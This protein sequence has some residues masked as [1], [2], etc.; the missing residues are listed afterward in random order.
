MET[1]TKN[2][3][4]GHVAASICMLIWGITFISSKVLLTHFSPTELFYFRF[5]LAYVF[6]FILSPKPIVPKLN[7]TELL[8]A[9]SGLTGVSLYFMFQNIGLQYTL[10]SNAGV[11]VAVAPM[12][13]AIVS[14]FFVSRSSLHR[15]FILG[16]FVSIA[17]VAIISFNGN[18]VLQLNPLGDLLIILGALAWGF[19]SNILIMIEEDGLSLIQRTRKAAFYGLLFVTP[20]L[21]FLDF[22]FG[23]E[24]FDNFQIIGNFLFLGIAASAISFVAWGYAVR[25]L[26]PVKAATYIY[27]NPIITVVA[28]II[29]LHEPFTWISFMGTALIIVGLLIAERRR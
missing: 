26:G 14:F 13:T 3:I 19:Y 24:R 8:Y 21:P 22:R 28:S 11:L 27:F 18:F 4:K 6:L 17:G 2:R 23:L 20:L 7:K 16:F 9:L 1:L 15:N 5:L 29:I 10:A 25:T 12:F